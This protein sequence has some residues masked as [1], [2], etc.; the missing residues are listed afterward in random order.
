MSHVHRPYHMFFP[1]VSFKWDEIWMCDEPIVVMH[2]S[3]VVMCIKKKHKGMAE[4]WLLF[5]QCP[6]EGLI[7]RKYM[8]NLN[9]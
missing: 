9:H 6:L 7:E 3:R 5:V 2:T 1:F 8:A 4:G